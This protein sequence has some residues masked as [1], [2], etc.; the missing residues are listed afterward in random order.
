MRGHDYYK[1][2]VTL[3]QLWPQLTCNNQPIAVNADIIYVGSL[4]RSGR[5]L[6]GLERSHS[7]KS[8]LVIFKTIVVLWQFAMIIFIRRTILAQS[9]LK[10]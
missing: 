10:S 1:A 6:V 3:S 2:Q 4:D 5:V 8:V 9:A 7:S